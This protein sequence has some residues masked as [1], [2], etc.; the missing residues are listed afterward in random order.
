MGK[1]MWTFWNKGYTATSI[2]DLVEHMDMNRFSIYSEFESKHGLFTAALNKYYQEISAKQLALLID[3]E[4]GLESIRIFFSTFLKL[5]KSVPNGCF[6]I[7]TVLEFGQT[8]AEVKAITGNYLKRLQDGFFTALERA[9]ESN[10][11]SISANLGDYAHQL[12][13]Y[14]FG[15][16]ALIKMRGA[17]ELNS[18]MNSY[19][20][21]FSEEAH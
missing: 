9:R 16:G 6:M 5:H 17:D 8:D 11:I 4:Q 14:H 1:A 15:L 13:S 7:N 2:N 18:G 20:Q 3:S 10:E 19:I 21:R 12:L